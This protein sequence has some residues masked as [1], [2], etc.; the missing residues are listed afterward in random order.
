MNQEKWV[1]QN[2]CSKLSKETMKMLFNFQ[3]IWHIFEKEVFNTNFQKSE[4]NQLS[5]LLSKKI[6]ENDLEKII[7]NIS[8]YFLYRYGEKNHINC[9]FSTFNFY[10]KDIKYDEYINCFS[11]SNSSDKVKV[12]LWI[13]YR[14]RNNWFHGIKCIEELDN[15]KL[16]FSTINSFLILCIDN[17]KD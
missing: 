9:S 17:F 4:I 11:S 10:E 16:L 12:L 2:F 3:V 5:I 1:E 15:Q 14:V 8:S 13:S 7:N 6:D